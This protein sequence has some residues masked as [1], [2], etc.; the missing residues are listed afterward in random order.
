[1]KKLF[2][3]VFTSVNLSSFCQNLQSGLVAHFPLNGNADDIS[4]LNIDG[5]VAGPTPTNGVLGVPSSAL[6]FTSLQTD[7][8]T[9]GTSDRGIT[10]QFSIS[11][12][13]KTTTTEID[14]LVNKYDWSVNRGF[15]IDIISGKPVL[16]G[17][18]GGAGAI[19]VYGTSDVTDGIWHHI[20]GTCNG[21]TWA[22]YVDCNLEATVTTV[23]ANP[24]FI[25][26]LPLTLGYYY[27][28]QTGDNRFYD[29]DMDEVRIYNR[30]LTTQE[31]ALLC[32]ENLLSDSNIEK[33]DEFLFS[34][35]DPHGIYSISWLKPEAYT[36]D[37]YSTTG[38]VVYSMNN[39][40]TID[41]QAHAAGIYLV[42]IRDK[43]ENVLYQTK[44]VKV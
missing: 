6:H 31:I 29:G 5:I 11:L 43:S 37:V 15:F 30:A 34:T 16:S 25:N 21:N 20:V 39:H 28:G 40:G 33:A 12:W 35:I 18:D 1:M 36:V 9:A 17:R 8:I 26:T 38:E 4:I 10:N 2:L 42:V 7:S 22:I 19:E 14:H 23:T 32:D 13:I 24:G 41:I 3:L 44:L 27:L